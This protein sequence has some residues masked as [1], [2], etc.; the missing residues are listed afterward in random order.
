MHTSIKENSMKKH[1]LSG[2]W[3]L[4]GY[5]HEM[6]VSS[7]EALDSCPIKICGKVPG[8]VD[9]DLSREGILPPDLFM[10]LNIKE[11]EGFE[12][13][14]W[15]YRT[16][17]KKPDGA[18][19]RLALLFE[20]V[21]CLA[22]Y[23]LNGELIG[24]SDNMFLPHEFEVTEKLCDENTLAVHI[25]SAMLHAFSKNYKVFSLANHRL[26]HSVESGFIRKAAHSFGWDIL[27]RAVSAGIFKDV[28][29]VEKDEYSFAQF[30]PFVQTFGKDSSIIRFCYELD[31]PYIPYKKELEL[32]VEGKCGNSYFKVERKIDFKAEFI[33]AQV[34]FPKLWWP[35]GYGEPNVYDITA[36]LKKDGNVVSTYTTNFGIRTVELD[37]TDTTNG[38]D[39][40]FRFL[41]NGVPV[42]CK[43]S[44][45]VPLD[46]YHSRDK[47][48]YEKALELCDDIGCNILR[49][50]G[51]GV[52]E[53]EIFYDYCDR[54]GIMIWQDFMMA[55]LAYPISEDFQKVM[56]EE[57]EIAIRMLR[58][59]PSIILWSGDNECD[60]FIK[61]ING[62]L[63]VNTITRESIPAAVLEN[64]MN[65]PYLPSSPYVTKAIKHNNELPENH[66]WGCRDYYK[67]AFYTQS[68]AH[69]VSETGYHG[70]PSKES[71]EKFITPENMWPIYNDEWSLHSTDYKLFNH[72]VKL[73]EDQIIQLFDF[74][75]EN[76]DDFVL[77]S[78]FS[79]A[80]ADKFFIERVRVDKPTKSGIIWW[81]ILDGWPQMSDAVVD[82]YYD[83]KKAYNYIKRSMENFFIM[84]GEIENWGCPIVASNDTLETKKGTY[85]VSD[86]ETGEVLASGD[87]EVEPNSNK[88][89]NHINVMY[90]AK[91]MFLIEWETDGKKYVNHYLHGFPPFD[92][93]AYTRW[94]EK[95][96]EIYKSL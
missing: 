1:I 96:E 28:Y 87:F 92:F 75:P 64:D 4:F 90:S 83:K 78:Q 84:S 55:C 88:K 42:M 77:A 32:T 66:L 58:N 15:W 35:K 23:Y 24:S 16:T 29:L 8:N 14:S 89:L 50:W 46:A 26:N 20:G 49:V 12:G 85:K 40:K 27:P 68:H 86:I 81:N 94:H 52:Y 93:K 10:G 74:V 6:S 13:H 61:N 48:R 82:Y 34:K 33:D 18:N 37:R 79:Q 7:P 47:E 57:A 60:Y 80:E 51:G 71:I 69:F 91:G 67:S 73:M 53:Q 30:Y 62:Q 63:D 44:N 9:L 95:L 72:R 38:Y 36:T 59:H 31:T 22:D 11:T 25:K 5:G 3:E 65:R 76:L 45:W 41:I 56:Y 43:G 70:C 19:G 21:D 39:G 2:D 54:H 17:F